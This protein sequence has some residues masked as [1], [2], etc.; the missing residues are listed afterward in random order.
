MLEGAH[1]RGRLAS[2][3]LFAGE[4]GIGKRM[5][6]LAFAARL[7]CTDPVDA[8]VIVDACGMCASCVKFE[9]GTHPDLIIIEPDGAQIKVEQIRQV[10]EALSYRSFEGG[11]KV[12]LV[13]NAEAM[14][15]A[16]S[17]AF[18]KTLEEPAPGCLI[19]LITSMP[20]RLLPT[21]RSRCSR[22][23]FKPL[24]YEQC[25]RA[26]QGSEVSKT[27]VRLSMGRPG[28][29]M[30]EDLVEERDNFHDTL[31]LMLGGE[32]KPPWKDRTE[33]ERFLDT[34][35]LMLRDIASAKTGS[36]ELM[37]DDMAAEITEMGSRT[38]IKKIL[39]CYQDIRKLRGRMFF[40]LNKGI[41]WNYTASLLEGLKL[42]G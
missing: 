18:L 28:L 31:D 38:S 9:A 5:T 39:E 20:D 40:N 13:D 8:G 29:A 2:T 7:N 14:N 37:N 42:H 36:G 11:Y 12:V 3:Y 15:P 34:T 17:N 27:G 6:A 35:M 25:N 30:T 10:E 33:S 22:I 1:R 23:N 32:A 16:A 41:T 19:I 4:N 26:L 21:I 24:S